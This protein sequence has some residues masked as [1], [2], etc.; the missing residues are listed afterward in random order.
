MS[1]KFV[2]RSEIVERLK[3]VGRRLSEYQ[4]LPSHS[5]VGLP[6]PISDKF[7]GC[8]LEVLDE[9]VDALS[10]S[11]KF[12]EAVSDFAT[13][14][15]RIRFELSRVPV[16]FLYKRH[17]RYNAYASPQRIE[18]WGFEREGR[19]LEFGSNDLPLD[20]L[21]E[22]IE[23]LSDGRV[24]CCFYPVDLAYKIGSDV[25][26]VWDK[27]TSFVSWVFADDLKAVR[28]EKE[29]DII[30]AFESWDSS[31]VEGRVPSEMP[32][33]ERV[34]AF[35]RERSS[36]RTQ[37]LLDQKFAGRSHT[38]RLLNQLESEGRITREHGICVVSDV[39]DTSPQS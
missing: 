1:G 33:K 12:E 21:P 22:D 6:V 4:K 32:A 36:V 34:Y 20:A 29:D 16:L 14:I 3:V 39:S 13:G 37:V 18:T 31:V 25:V 2:W 24:V 9:C 38:F 27:D 15:D 7:L 17:V 8:V 28:R 30:L 5:S 19:R 26:P 23:D 11:D 10:F 35:I